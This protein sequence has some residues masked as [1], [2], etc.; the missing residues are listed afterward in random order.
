MHR[1]SVITKHQ[2]TGVEVQQLYHNCPFF[3][4]VLCVWLT[5]WKQCVVWSLHANVFDEIVPGGCAVCL[6]VCITERIITCVNVCMLIDR[7][8]E[9]WICDVSWRALVHTKLCYIINLKGI[10]LQ[11]YFDVLCMVQCQELP[12]P[13]CE[14]IRISNDKSL[15]AK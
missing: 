10:L 1:L 11:M 12:L 8:W 2:L 3:S 13:H 6:N 15:C 14:K 4:G 7:K 5:K 9:G